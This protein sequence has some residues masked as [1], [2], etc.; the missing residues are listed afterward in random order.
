MSISTLICTYKRQ[1]LL[2]KCLETIIRK[3]IE[4]PDEIVIVD[5]E[6]GRAKNIVVKYQK[7][8]PN[9]KLISAKNINL[10]VSRN[11]GLPHCTGDII[12][13]T[14]DDVI[15]SSD[16]VKRIKELH[17][18]H[19]EAGAIGGKI[20]SVGNKL[21]D[22]VADLVIFQ[23]P[24]KADYIRTV[25][26]ANA[27]YKREAIKAVGK[28]DETLFRGEDVDYN[29]R[30]LE[31]GYKIYYDPRLVVQHCH[32]ATWRGLFRQVFMYGKAYCLVR[33]KWRNMYCVYPH[34]LSYCSDFLKLGYFFIGIF[35][36]PI[37]QFK[38]I[39]GFFWKAVIYPLLVTIQISWRFGMLMG[40]K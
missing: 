32:R 27:S 13:L 28:F 23:F 14:D 8:F 36:E 3:S 7:E 9:I 25:A 5:G 22:K 17:K 10:A 20:I 4:L 30:V 6:E 26:G 38:K 29:W 12:A 11:I 24:D 39:K 2:E 15:A 1:K 33:R 19:P 16:W 40:Y 18:E 35:A 37:A 34:T 21:L 31:K